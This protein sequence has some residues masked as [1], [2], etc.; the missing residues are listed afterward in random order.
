[1][2]ENSHDCFDLAANVCV[3]LNETAE[4][5][6]RKIILAST[7]IFKAQKGGENVKENQPFLIVEHYLQ[8]RIVNLPQPQEWMKNYNDEQPVY[9]AMVELVGNEINFLNGALQKVKQLIESNSKEL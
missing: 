3:T 7:E 2:N 4:E 8:E 6:E 1:M 9:R 5:F